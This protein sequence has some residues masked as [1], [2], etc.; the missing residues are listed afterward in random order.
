MR[1]STR[2]NLGQYSHPAAKILAAGGISVFLS[3][4]S[5]IIGRAFMQTAPNLAFVRAAVGLLYNLTIYS[6]VLGVLAALAAFGVSLHMSE[7]AKIRLMIRKRL[8]SPEY[9]NPLHLKEG[10]RLPKITC[11]ET[12]KGIFE[13]TIAATCCT[14]KEIQDKIGRAHV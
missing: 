10:E 5:M 2:P 11:R 13:I 9:G 6:F 14:V 12:R 1:Y 3:I 8:F 4:L 7:A